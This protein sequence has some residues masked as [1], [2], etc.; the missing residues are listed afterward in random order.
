[1]ITGR[2]ARQGIS[3]NPQRSFAS[4]VDLEL[5]ADPAHEFV[6]RVMNGASA[7]PRKSAAA[8]V[9]SETPSSDMV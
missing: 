2:L 6:E 7:A 1:M 9:M 4:L 8:L 5:L 3:R